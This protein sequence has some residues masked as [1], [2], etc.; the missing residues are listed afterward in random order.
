M[1]Y[2]F[3]L[4]NLTC[5]VFKYSYYKGRMRDQIQTADAI[6]RLYLSIFDAH[7][8]SDGSNFKNHIRIC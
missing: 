1:K 3:L 2:K 4:V 5:L 6:N 8:V 7:Q